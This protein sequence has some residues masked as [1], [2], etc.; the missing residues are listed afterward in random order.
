M[1]S[2]LSQSGQMGSIDRLYNLVAGTYDQL[3]GL[4]RRKA[5]FDIDNIMLKAYGQISDAK[6][7]R[8]YYDKL[9]SNDLHPDADAYAALLLATANDPSFGS[10]DAM[11]IY[12]EAKKHKIKPTAYFYNVIISRLSQE[13]RWTEAEALFKEMEFRGVPP[14]AVTYNAIIH[15]CLQGSREDRA[16]HYLDEMVNRSKYTPKVGLYNSLMQYYVRQRGD[17]DKA[18]NYFSRIKQQHLK[19]T[20]HTYRL[21]IEAYANVPDYDMT[22]ARR[23]L[24]EMKQRH[25]EYPRPAHYAVLIKS[26]GCLRHDVPSAEAVFEEMVKADIKPNLPVYEALIDTYITNNRMKQAEDLYKQMASEHTARVGI[27]NHF[28]QGY[29]ANGQVD[30]AE[31]V[32]DRM[33]DGAGRDPSTYKTMAKVYM[34]HDQVDKATEILNLMKGHN[35][36]VKVVDEVALLVEGQSL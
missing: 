1:I 35:Y 7:A 26:Y 10:L 20:V 25:G 2:S 16:L 4:L 27:E 24:L 28:I 18:L 8:L 14:D 31:Q 3:P 9:R 33:V 19:P 30:K 21:I 36:P 22:A 11:A 23:F 5:T 6:M 15:A 29:G 32:F 17:R 13:Q 34:E 12:E